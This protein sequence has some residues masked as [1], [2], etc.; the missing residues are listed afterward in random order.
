M[1]G[2][3][4]T[5]FQKLLFE[6]IKLDN[7]VITHSLEIVERTTYNLFMRRGEIH[8]EVICNKLEERV[9]CYL[10]NRLLSTNEK[11]QA[12]QNLEALQKKFS[13]SD[14]STDAVC[15]KKLQ[16]VINDVQ[17]ADAIYSFSSPSEDDSSQKKVNLKI[18][19]IY[20]SDSLEEDLEQVTWDENLYRQLPEKKEKSTFQERLDRFFPEQEWA[21]QTFNAKSFKNARSSNPL[22]AHP[23]S[24]R[25]GN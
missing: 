10:K 6:Q 21:N 18:T 1:S 7:S 4:D 25:I 20:L 16:K 17:S 13:G 15:Y 5:N 8:K 23:K 9:D 14:Q 3:I 12:V 22:F 24:K 11:E 2:M 19:E